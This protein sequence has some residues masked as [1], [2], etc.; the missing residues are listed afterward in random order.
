MDSLLSELI[1]FICDL[2]SHKS[3]ILMKQ[4]SKSWYTKMFNLDPIDLNRLKVGSRIFSP[5]C[6][7][8][9]INLHFILKNEV[10][11]N[12]SLYHSENHNPCKNIRHYTYTIVI[13][14]KLITI[15]CSS[16][17]FH[18]LENGKVSN[19]LE[20]LCLDFKLNNNASKFLDI[21]RVHTE[22]F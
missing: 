22:A 16:G 5:R 3:K 15:I 7:L 19:V 9:V 18:H 6:C 11:K 21:N 2:M 20:K 12:L 1:D 17:N 4:T 10:Y 13:N 8:E 14:K